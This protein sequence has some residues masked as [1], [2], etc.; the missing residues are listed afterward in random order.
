MSKYAEKKVQKRVRDRLGGNM[1]SNTYH[2]EA[3]V[4]NITP[5]FLSPGNAQFSTPLGGLPPQVGTNW[6]E[7][8]I[9]RF[10]ADYVYRSENVRQFNISFIIEIA[11]ANKSCACIQEALRAVALISLAN[12]T[13]QKRLETEASQYFYRAVGLLAK[14]LQDPEEAKKD[15]TLASTFLFGWYT[16]SS[17]CIST[18]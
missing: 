2:S 15:T 13:H 10:F 8:A 11:N 1:G 4:Q 17:C 12:Q 6:M 5:T 9:P 14:S 18:S 3:V 16:V 7:I